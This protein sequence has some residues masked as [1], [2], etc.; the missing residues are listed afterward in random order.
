MICCCFNWLILVWVQFYLS[1]TIYLPF[2]FFCLLIDLQHC[3]ICKVMLDSKLFFCSLEWH[4]HICTAF[5]TSDSIIYLPPSSEGWGRYCF[6]RCLSVHTWVWGYPCLWSQV[7]SQPLVPRPFLVTPVPGSFPDLSS[8]SFLGGGSTP[9]PGSFSDLWSLVPGPFWG[10]P[11]AGGERGQ[12]PS[13]R[14]PC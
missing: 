6:H 2:E 10:T 5:R 8:R 14:Y 1:H 12:Y 11:V 7:P 13:S 4:L 3:V 9:V